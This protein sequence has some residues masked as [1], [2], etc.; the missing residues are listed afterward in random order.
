M[1]KKIS[2]GLCLDQLKRPDHPIIK[3]KCMCNILCHKECFKKYKRFMSRCTYCYDTIIKTITFD[4]YTD[5]IEAVNEYRT[6]FDALEDKYGSNV[7]YKRR[8]LNIWEVDAISEEIKRSA[9]RI[10]DFIE[11]RLEKSG[12]LE[13]NIVE[14]ILHNRKYYDPKSDDVFMRLS[15]LQNNYIAY[16][17]TFVTENDIDFKPV[18]RQHRDKDLVDGVSDSETD[19]EDEAEEKNVSWSEVYDKYKK[20]IKTDANDDTESESETDSD[21]EEV[22]NKST[23]RHYE[24]QSLQS[25]LEQYEKLSKEKAAKEAAKEVSANANVNVKATKAASANTAKTAKKKSV[26]AK[27]AKKKTVKKKAAKVQVK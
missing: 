11:K 10:E 20:S 9:S 26:N 24:K 27:T 19:S 23:T 2:C 14:I 1:N 6:M 13:Q 17:M 5:S 25:L 18:K 21:D 4:I 7:G 22:K 15:Q 16:I 8:L 12:S 3:C